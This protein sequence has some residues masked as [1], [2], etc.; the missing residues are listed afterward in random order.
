MKFNIPRSCVTLT[1][2]SMSFKH[3]EIKYFVTY[4]ICAK[5][6]EIWTIRSK[7]KTLSLFFNFSLAYKGNQIMKIKCSQTKALNL[8]KFYEQFALFM[9]ASACLA[10]NALKLDHLPFQWHKRPLLLHP[11]ML[12]CWNWSPQCLGW[13]P[14]NNIVFLAH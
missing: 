5:F 8:Y 2:E 4:N 10:I 13:S 12:C 1:F 11:Q 7:V 9:S 14:A 3:F 6:R